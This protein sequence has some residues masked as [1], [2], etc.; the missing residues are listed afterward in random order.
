MNNEERG[1]HERNGIMK[2]INNYGMFTKIYFINKVKAMTKFT[3]L[4]R[5]INFAFLIVRT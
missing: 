5:E 3:T 4:N 2:A 1:N